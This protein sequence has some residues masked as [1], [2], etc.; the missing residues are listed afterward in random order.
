[1]SRRSQGSGPD[2]LLIVVAI[3]AVICLMGPAIALQLKLSLTESAVILLPIL[4]P[5]LLVALGVL[6]FRMYW[7]RY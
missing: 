2:T 3:L 6:I 4:G 7:S 1:M 5:V